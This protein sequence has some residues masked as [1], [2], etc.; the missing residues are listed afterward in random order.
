KKGL[1]TFNNKGLGWFS[2]KVNAQC[3]PWGGRSTP[4]EIPQ[5]NL[6][7]K[8]KN[9]EGISFPQTPLSLSHRNKR[10]PSLIISLGY[11]L[12]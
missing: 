9:H 2:K 4:Q 10:T 6:K 1:Q 7:A 5:K 11:R 8:T 12:S 3:T